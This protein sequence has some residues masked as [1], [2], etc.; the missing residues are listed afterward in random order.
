M[1]IKKKEN[2]GNEGKGAKRENEIPRK[3][4]KEKEEVVTRSNSSG[5]RLGDPPSCLGEDLADA[6]RFYFI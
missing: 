5:M 3:N 2:Q 1:Q 4:K 6:T